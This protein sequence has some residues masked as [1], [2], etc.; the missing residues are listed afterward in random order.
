[1][2]I[3]RFR[4]KFPKFRN[5]VKKNHS[6]RWGGL[7]RISGLGEFI[8]TMQYLAIR[9][10]HALVNLD[11]LNSLTAISGELEIYYN[12]SLENI[13]GLSNLLTAGMVRIWENYSLPNCVAVDLVMGLIGYD[14]DADL[15]I[16]NRADTCPGIDHN[17]V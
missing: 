8:T 4:E 3:G 5:T 12:S 10:N 1:M 13:G 16:S 7:T 17:C 14:V 6:Q 9:E 2:Q 11:G 15:C